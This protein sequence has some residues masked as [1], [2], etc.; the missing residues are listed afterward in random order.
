MNWDEDHNKRVAGF[1]GDIQA[2]H[3]HSIH[4]RAEIMLSTLCGC[5]HCF[6]TFSPSD[7][8]EWTDQEDTA[9]CP[10]CGIDSVIGDRAGFPISR[11]F[12]QTMKA[13]W[14]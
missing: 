2:A 6:A 10:K 12:L 8:S 3:K 1:P 7:V 9:L 5:F 4:H 11:E 13:H 14:F